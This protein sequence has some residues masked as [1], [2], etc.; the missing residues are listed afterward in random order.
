MTEE[1]RII[2]IPEE[3]MPMVLEL[4]KRVKRPF[5]YPES[6]SPGWRRLPNNLRFGDRKI[7]DK[8]CCPMGLHPKAKVSCPL[9]YHGFSP[10][11]IKGINGRVIQQFASWWDSQTN[12]KA[13]DLIWPLETTNET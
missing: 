12:P 13:M 4:R 10:L 5:K 2:P 8:I 11:G 3:I 9:T 6:F 7:Y 1:T